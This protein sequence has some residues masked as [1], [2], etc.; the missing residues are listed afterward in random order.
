MMQHT[1]THR[2]SPPPSSSKN[3]NKKPAAAN[4]TRSSARVQKKEPKLTIKTSPHSPVYPGLVSPVSLASSNEDSD[5]DDDIIISSPP[6]QQRRRLSIAELCN[7]PKN[8]GMPDVQLTKD[9]FEALEGFG[10]FGRTPSVY[11]D[12]LR[13]LALIANIDYC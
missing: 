9:E 8:E 3:S 2:A 11:L 5:Y 1:Q 13:D 10:R 12:S 7:H 6:Q 4:Q